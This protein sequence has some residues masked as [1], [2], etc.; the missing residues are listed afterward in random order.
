MKIYIVMVHDWIYRDHMCKN[1][2]EEDISTDILFV[3]HVKELAIRRANE[4]VKD[5]LADLLTYGDDKWQP[6]EKVIKRELTENEI[7]FEDVE[8]LKTTDCCW[9]Y[10]TPDGGYG[11]SI[12]G[13]DV[14]FNIKEE[15]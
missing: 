12:R 11:I 8:E 1:M 6:E 4:Y 2:Y 5:D 10:L 14:D 9:Y 15:D 3:T 13:Y 7:V